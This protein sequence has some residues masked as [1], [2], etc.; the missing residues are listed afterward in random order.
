M[1]DICNMM[2]FASPK[3]FLKLLITQVCFVSDRSWETQE[4][5]I[6]LFELEFAT[7]RADANSE[8]KPRAAWTSKIISTWLEQY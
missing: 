1:I 7:V 5:R 8:E 6:S 2:G 3:N 4:F